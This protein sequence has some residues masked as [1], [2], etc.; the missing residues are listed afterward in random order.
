[1]ERF[2]V[3]SKSINSHFKIDCSENDLEFWK[4]VCKYDSIEND[5]KCYYRKFP[6]SKNKKV[7]YSIEIPNITKNELNII[8]CKLKNIAP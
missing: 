7:Y 6:V 2:R 5:G 8:A 1:M 4:A 3:E